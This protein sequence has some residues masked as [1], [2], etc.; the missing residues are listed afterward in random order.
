[1]SIQGNRRESKEFDNQ[2]VVGLAEVKVLCVN[3]SAEEYKEILGIELKEDSK[4]TEYLGEDKDGNTSLRINFWVE[5][6]KS[7]TRFSLNYYLADKVRENKDATK[8]QYI[9]NIGSCSWADDV[10]NLPQW[11]VKRDYREAHVGEEE[12]YSFLRTWINIDYSQEGAE[13]EVNWKKLMRGRVDEIKEIL[14]HDNAP[15]TKPEN[16][17]SGNIVI[18]ATVVSKEKDGE[19]K[20]YQ[21][22]YKEVIPA[23]TLKQFRLVDYSSTETLDRLKAKKPKD[24]KAWERFA[25][26]VSGE[27]GCKDFFS[28]KELHDYDPS[29]NIAASNSVIASDD[30]SY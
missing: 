23:Y 18:L 26:S 24:L 14:D 19:Y 16:R 4:A 5:D 21:G 7:G 11:F 20:E 9:N 30:S 13:L 17:L 29:E 15:T 25:I 10:N 3:P 6:I 28:L 27:Y 2:L 8:K 22:V 1:M 12:L